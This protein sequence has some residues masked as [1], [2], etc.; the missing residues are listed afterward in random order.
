[1]EPNIEQVEEAV[2]YLIWVYNRVVRD[3]LASIFP[4]VPLTKRPQHK[5]SILRPRDCV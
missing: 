5:P 2:Y 1:M 4:H 3:G